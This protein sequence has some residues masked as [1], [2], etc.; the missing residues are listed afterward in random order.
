MALITDL[1]EA[2]LKHQR[3]AILEYPQIK[4]SL[5]EIM[6]TTEFGSRCEID[7]HKN[8][9]GVS[10]PDLVFIPINVFFF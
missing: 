5:E 8:G 9:P 3:S 1:F 7:I 2:Y 10:K 4:N 6:K